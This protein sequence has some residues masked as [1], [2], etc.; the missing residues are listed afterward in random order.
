V[1]VSYLW[2]CE[3]ID[4]RRLLSFA[5]EMHAIRLAKRRCD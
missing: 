1:P 3:L 4:P 2:K 5:F